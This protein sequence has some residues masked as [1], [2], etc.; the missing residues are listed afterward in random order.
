MSN[1]QVFF[2]SKEWK[3]LGVVGDAVSILWTEFFQ[4][5][6]SFSIVVPLKKD[7]IELC[8]FENFVYVHD[9]ERIKTN[10]VGII[11][12]IKKSNDGGNKFIEIRG[13]FLESLFH[14]R[15]I[16][17]ESAIMN[18]DTTGYTGYLP[19]LLNRAVYAMFTNFGTPW[20]MDR[21]QIRWITANSYTEDIPW[22]PY[23][24]GIKRRGRTLF[25]LIQDTCVAL[26]CGFRL[27]PFRFDLPSPLDPNTDAFL[28]DLYMGVDRTVHQNAVRPLVFSME[29]NSVTN[30]EYFLSGY[31]NPEFAF[32]AGQGEGTNRIIREVPREGW[33][34]VS[35]T[36]PESYRNRRGLDCR[37]MWV[38]A[39]DM[40]RTD[41]QT[42]DQYL[43]S[44]E[45][46][47]VTKINENQMQENFNADVLLQEN[48]V[49]TV[50]FNLGDKCT[51]RDTEI[52]VER[53]AVIAGVESVWRQGG[54]E[55]RILFGNQPQTVR[56]VIDNATEGLAN[57]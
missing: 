33:R 37:E 30:A 54:F 19:R 40:Q 45:V 38:D 13:R 46:R 39:R 51:Y 10:K 11:E 43:S 27:V 8:R 23:Q 18:S 5:V 56:R 26:D 42:N 17:S 36:D 1:V 31:E 6:G 50:D 55:H 52:G 57:G 41:T 53:D 3:Q 29:T 25:K 21:R 12:Y 35:P 47:G 14:R 49:Y 15:V 28:F 16:Q 34:N 20:L 4:D 22:G 32:V 24:Y 7:Y 2:Y 44:L 9:A 48:L